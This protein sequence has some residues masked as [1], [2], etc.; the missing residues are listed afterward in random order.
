MSRASPVISPSRQRITPTV[1]DEPLPSFPSPPPPMTAAM[2]LQPGD[3]EEMGRHIEA[4]AEIS[5]RLSQSRSGMGS[6]HKPRELPS[7]A[8]PHNPHHRPPNMAVSDDVSA[9][10]DDSDSVSFQKNIRGWD[11]MKRKGDEIAIGIETPLA[12]QRQPPSEP[13]LWDWDPTVRPHPPLPLPVVAAFVV[14]AAWALTAWVWFGA[15]RAVPV[16]GR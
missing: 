2:L 16:S 12:R 10:N 5:A 14:A 3:V 7:P 8:R 9:P 6:F 15:A 1:I 13:D 4:A 11:A